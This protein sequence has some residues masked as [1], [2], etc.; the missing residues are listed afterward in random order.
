M[1]RDLFNTI[2]K[3]RNMI[4]RLSQEGMQL[5]ASAIRLLK[6]TATMGVLAYGCLVDAIDDYVRIGEDLILD[7]VRRFCDAV[8]EIYGPR[9]LEGSQ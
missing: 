4:L 1:H 9:V 2:A 5:A 3:G 7:C 8:T 6:I